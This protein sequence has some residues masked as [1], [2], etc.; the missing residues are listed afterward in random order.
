MDGCQ[1][2]IGDKKA[3]KRDDESGGTGVKGAPSVG[4]GVGTARSFQASLQPF[5]EEND[6]TNSHFK[7]LLF[8]LFNLL[9]PFL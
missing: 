3:P 1:V 7:D 6:Q 4:V 9:F 5:M 8:V 2:C